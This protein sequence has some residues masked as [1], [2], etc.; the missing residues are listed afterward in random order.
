MHDINVVED[1]LKKNADKENNCIYKKI[2]KHWD[3]NEIRW[4]E[5]EKW[6]KGQENLNKS[7]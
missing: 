3:E 2:K 7:L 4:E 1:R 5:N 6:C